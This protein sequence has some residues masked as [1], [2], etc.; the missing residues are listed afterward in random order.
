[1][2]GN[3]RKTDVLVVG[4]GPIGQWAALLLAERGVHVEIIDEERM[5]SGHQFA[6]VLHPASLQLLHEMGLTKELIAVGHRIEKIDFRDAQGVRASLD[7]TRLPTQY[8]FALTLQLADLETALE[9]RLN[10]AGVAV[11]WNHRLGDLDTTSDPVVAEVHKLNTVSMGYPFMDTET[12]VEKTF[13]IESAFVIGADGPHSLVRRRMNLSASDAGRPER[14]LVF[15]GHTTVPM[16]NVLTVVFHAEGAAAQWPLHGNRCRW[17]FELGAPPAGALDPRY[18]DEVFSALGGWAFRRVDT[19]ALTTLLEQR[20]PW[21][22]RS[23]LAVDFGIDLLAERRFVKHFG[24]GRVW[25]AGDAAHFNGPLANESL[26]DGLREAHDLVRRL[27]RILRGGAGDEL[28]AD[29]DAERFHEWRAV[30]GLHNQP[31]VSRA[32]SPWIAA[33]AA[34]FGAF[35]PVTGAELGHLFEQV[36]LA[37]P[38]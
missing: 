17:V 29:Y 23:A 20:A 18:K 7:L 6:V 4:A 16:R 32:G 21:F 38:S 14:F 22:E 27:A 15:E 34:R 19:T 26:N 5:S 33:H 2:F 36:G 28:M 37:P 24:A 12:V 35:V 3:R 31:D 13:A 25:L 8:P 1:M 10:G 9:R 11:K 30:L